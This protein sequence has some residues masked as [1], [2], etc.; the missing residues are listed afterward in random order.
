VFGEVVVD[1]AG[2]FSFTLPADAFIGQCDAGPVGSEAGQYRIAV[3]TGRGPKVGDDYR[4]PSAQAIFTHVV[5]A[6]DVFH[7]LWRRTEQPV[8]DGAAQRTWLWGP[9]SLTGELEEPYFD[10]PDGLRAVQYFDKGRMEVTYPNADWA[11]GWYVTNGLLVTEMVEGRV[12]NGD[13]SFVDRGAPAEINVAGDLD[14]SAGPTYHTIGLVRDQ[15]AGTDLAI[16]TQRLSRDGS[17]SEDMSL[18]NHKVYLAQRVTVPG[19]DHQI[20]SVFWVFMNSRGLVDEHGELVDA[21][22]FLNPFH[23]VGLPI[24]EPYWVT[25]RVDG[26]PQDVLLQCFERRCLTYT[27]NNPLGWQVEAGNVGQHYY[28]WRYEPAEQG[29]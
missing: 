24:T 18:A 12:Q 22:L 13:V 17:I 27:P 28:Q 23:A 1:G 3:S 25:V 8:S 20:A 4:E 16:V 2:A 6:S 29:G 19:I 14:D 11:S 26:V 7:Q 21:P 15:P 10:S 5:Q 9:T